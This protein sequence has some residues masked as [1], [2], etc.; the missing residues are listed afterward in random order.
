MWEMLARRAKDLTLTFNGIRADGERGQAH[1][2]AVYT[3]SETGRR[4]HNVIDAEFAFRDGKIVKHKDRFNLWR[5]A[6]MALGPKGM[7]LGWLPQVQSAIRKKAAGN[8]D[9]YLAQAKAD[10]PTT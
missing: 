4:V 1:W 2:E 8:L 5:W 9:R 3:F 6:A 10:L 7:A